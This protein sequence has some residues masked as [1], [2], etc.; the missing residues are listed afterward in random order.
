MTTS[1]AARQRTEFLARLDAAMQSVPHGVATEIRAGIVEELDGLDAAATAARIEQLGDPAVIAREA[2]GESVHAVTPAAPEKVPLTQSRGFAIAAALT[3][4]FGG[5]IVPVV[6][7]LVGAVLVAIGARWRRWEKVLA[8]A[9]PFAVGAVM[10]LVTWIVRLTVA[11]PDS[12][13][14]PLLPASY[15]LWISGILLVLLIIPI[16]GGWL[17]WRLRRG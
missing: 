3:L 11:R 17:L 16:S 10:G 4:S 7:W 9:L 1:D 14:N 12:G 13:H 15:D 2:G 8:I 5:F 6:G